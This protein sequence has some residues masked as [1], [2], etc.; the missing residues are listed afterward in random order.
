MLDSGGKKQLGETLGGKE[1][2][3]FMFVGQLMLNIIH[4]F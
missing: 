4:R 3:H 1:N 2:A